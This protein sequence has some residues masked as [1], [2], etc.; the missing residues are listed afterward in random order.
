MKNATPCPFCEWY[1]RLKSWDEYYENGT[2]GRSG[3]TEFKYG[4]ALVHET[5]YNGIPCGR[6]VYDTEPLCYCPTCGIKLKKE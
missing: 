4:A 5:Y 6:S 3:V 2:D 1:Q